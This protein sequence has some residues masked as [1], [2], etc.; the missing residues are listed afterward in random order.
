M[1]ARLHTFESFFAG[2]GSAVH[3]A[4]ALLDRA[5]R[6]IAFE[7]LRYANSARNGGAAVGGASSA[8]LMAFAAEVWPAVSGSRAWRRLERA[9]SR[10]SAGLT[11]YVGATASRV[12]NAVLWRRWRRY[13]L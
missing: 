13:G 6:S 11:R 5:R 4:T 9:G 10:P 3:G 2:S 7:A 1:R 12:R 8:E